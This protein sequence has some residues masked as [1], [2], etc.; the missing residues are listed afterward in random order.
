MCIRDRGKYFERYDCLNMMVKLTEF[1]TTQ[2]ALKLSKKSNSP[3]ATYK[4]VK[5]YINKEILTIFLTDFISLFL[6]SCYFHLTI[7]RKVNSRI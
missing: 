6:L 4:L 7:I 3:W 2:V 1:L 5:C